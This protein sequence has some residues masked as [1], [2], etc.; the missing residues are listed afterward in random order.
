[1]IKINGSLFIDERKIEEDFMRSSGPGGQNV[2][3]VETAVRIRFN[4][5]S[6][7]LPQDIKERLI[8]IAGKRISSSGDLIITARKYRTQESNRRDA[9]DR[10]VILIK[11]ACEKKQRRK[12]TRPTKSSVEK[13][14][15]C[16]RAESIKKRNRTG[17]TD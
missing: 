17:I 4:I 8:H 11:K 12:K 3:K 7:G 16:K 1:M 13:R 15:N 14:L 5:D 6:S 2:N 9:L 10:L